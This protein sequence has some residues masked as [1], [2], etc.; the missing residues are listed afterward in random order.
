M[1]IIIYFLIFIIGAFIGSFTS[2]AIHRLPLKQD[3]FYTHSY[4]PNCKNK[5]KIIDL[6]PIFSY[7]F[8][9]GKCRNC[10]EKI[11]I[12]YFLLEI[13][14]GT[15]TLCFV[16]SMGLDFY[17]I[18]LIDIIRTIF[19][20]IFITTLIIISGIDKEKNILQK[21][22]MIF[23]II[24]EIIYILVFQKINLYHISLTII[25]TIFLIF[26]KNNY[27]LSF[28][29]LFLYTLF[30]IPIQIIT[31]SLVGL[32]IYMI[33]KRNKRNNIPIMYIYTITTISI[34]IIYNFM[35]RVG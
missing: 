4:C 27:N 1:E 9:K 12:R 23:G 35:Q 7:I 3:I 18:N 19:Y 20:I 13:F 21:N 34:F 8:L 11:R 26:N 2:L 5:L 17:N 10:G 14:A 29:I 30:F 32:L 28:F 24:L 33:I 16:L 6:I 31:P 15:I 25:L 22:V